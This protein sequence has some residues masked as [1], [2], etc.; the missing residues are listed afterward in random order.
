MRYNDNGPLVARRAGER[1]TKSSL[2]SPVCLPLAL[3]RGE[4]SPPRAREPQAL[5]INSRTTTRDH[6]QPWYCRAVF[7]A[8]GNSPSR[9]IAFVL[10][11]DRAMRNHLF[12]HLRL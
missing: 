12:S 4:S 9:S 8:R 11:F 2:T 5:E 7:T 1:P 10:P 6:T 3:P